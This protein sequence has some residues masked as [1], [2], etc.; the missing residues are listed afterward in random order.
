MPRVIMNVR[1]RLRPTLALAGLLALF[2]AVPLFAADN[3]PIL[4]LSEIHP[5]M[6][7]VMYTIFS[8]DQ[9]QQVNLTVIGI[10]NNALGP[11]EDIILVQLEGP[12]VEKTG[13]VAGMSGSPVYI[14]GKLAGALSLKIGTFTKDAIAGVTPIQN[15]LD[16]ENAIPKSGTAQTDYSE[17]LAEPQ[18]AEV[19]SS[20]PDKIELGSGNFLRPIETP[21][22]FSG[23]P[24]ETLNYFAP[25]FQ[26]LGMTAM[27]GGT[28]PPSPDD[29]KL[30]PGDMVG[31]DL[32]SGDMSLSAGCTV[33][34]II[35]NQVFVCGH[36][37]L[38]LGNVSLP[39]SR[40]HVVMTLASS[41]ESTKIMNSGGNIGAFTQDRL[42]GVVGD[43]GPAPP[44]IPVDVN[45]STPTEQKHFHFD[46][47]ENPKITPLLVA[48]AANS[49]ISGNTAYEDGSTLQ[50]DGQINI[51]GHP[52]VDLRNIFAPT[53]A[54]VGGAVQLALTVE[55]AFSRIYTNPYEP[56]KVEK[57]VLN[58]TS[59]P[60]RHTST[61]DAAWAD[62]SEVTPGDTV[63]IKVL[64]RPYRG[65]P[66]IREIPVTIPDQAAT[67]NLQIL[68]SDA[69][70]LDRMREIFGGAEDNDLH[71]LDE[72]IRI[73][74]RERQ[75]DRLYVTLL[76]NAPTLL[77][78]DKE[79]PN[80]PA[81]EMNVLDQPR[82]PGG[83]RMLFQS[84]LGENS[85][86]MEQVISGE[87]YLS[88]TIK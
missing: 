86:Q 66:Y 77:V 39:M 10:M 24:P 3:P 51:E 1:M 32:V 48:L 5:G 70:S 67:G 76:Q 63:H 54:P 17:S 87:Q 85:I 59:T 37:I 34:A 64:L 36:P 12:E 2:S 8:G 53:D 46:V 15:M 61:I 56:P 57:V 84:V 60:G 58:I 40:G 18:S 25:Q 31:M 73:I 11:K 13:V 44:T 22:V 78:E 14:E 35:K 16:I 42:T 27:A 26:A 88:I 23:V 47:A 28:A 49:G 80:I 62:K 38:S 69:A 79:L 29:A 43:L 74:N 75:N 9:I 33:T 21:L 45:L 19:G 52:S 55:S 82:I 50:L 72:L 6:N 81:S 7:G 71:G 65:R 4:P 41:L 30:Q 83:T 20:F 68:V